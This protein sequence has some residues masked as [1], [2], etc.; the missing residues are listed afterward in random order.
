MAELLQRNTSDDVRT[1][2]FHISLETGYITR[3]NAAYVQLQCGE[4]DVDAVQ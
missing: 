3:V 4:E 2:E 1:I